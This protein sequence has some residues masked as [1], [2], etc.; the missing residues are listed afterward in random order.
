MKIP[1]KVMDYFI[2]QCSSSDYELDEWVLCWDTSKSWRNKILKKVVPA[3][4]KQ[5]FITY[6]NFRIHDKKG[7]NNLKL[8][9]NNISYL[10]INVNWIIEHGKKEKPNYHIHILGTIRNSKNFKRNIS[11]EWNRIFKTVFH[12]KNTDFYLLKQ[13]SASE[14]MPPY[15]Q[16]LRE[17]QK[18]FE[19]DAKGDHG[20]WIDLGAEFKK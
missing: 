17:K 8:W 20:N 14:L 18:Y 7:L 10:F 1:T 2:E 5:V 16:W 4:K 12:P 13:W 9:M 15:I 6:Q 3:D 11:I 19:Q